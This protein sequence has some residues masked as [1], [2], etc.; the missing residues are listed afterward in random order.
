[1]TTWPH[2]ITEADA[3]DRLLPK[4]IAG[5]PFAAL[6]PCTS[7]GGFHFDKEGCLLSAMQFQRPGQGDLAALNPEPVYVCRKCGAAFIWLGEQLYD[8]SS[9][10]RG[11]A[12]AEQSA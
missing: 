1:M 10:T 2:A 4:E 9:I 7:C 6:N 3:M 8:V 5:A 12:E 11:R